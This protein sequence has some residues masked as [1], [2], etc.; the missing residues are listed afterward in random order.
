MEEVLFGLWIVAIIAP[1][2]WAWYHK[3][4]I[5]MAMTLSL[6]FGYIVQLMWGWV[7]EYSELSELYIRV[8]M[9]PVLVEEGY[10]HTLI[11]SGFLHSWSDP[12]H[13]LGN[14]III[15]LVGIPLEERLGRGRWLISYTIGLLGGSIAWT[16]ANSGSYTPA[17]GASGAAFGILGA[18]MCGWPDDEVYFPL[19]LIRKW[20]VQF[21]A[22]FYFGF[23]I[24]NAWRVY[25]LSEVS[26]V[27]HIAH[28]GGFILAYATLPILKKGI[29]WDGEAELVELKEDHPFE[30]VDELVKRLLAEG[31]EKETRQ[32]WLEEIAERAKC[33]EC[34]G[35]LH[36]KK[37]RIRCVADASHVA[38]P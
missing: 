4:S 19:I 25:G 12:L 3:A 37:M 32:A 13:V 29:E 26:H 16:L 30:G 1:L 38:W 2:A 14:I 8:L 35:D 33:P 10:F 9:I 7:L 22:L 27:A 18:Y 21:I 6:L 36:L 28:F 20:P 17:L 11:T 24:F 34:D 5:S 31:D 15:A 23:E